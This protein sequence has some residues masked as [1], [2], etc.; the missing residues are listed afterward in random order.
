M[1]KLKVL[2]LLVM[3]AL[4]VGAVGALALEA[5]LVYEIITIYDGDIL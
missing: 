2:A 3:L 4:S 1:I 5:R